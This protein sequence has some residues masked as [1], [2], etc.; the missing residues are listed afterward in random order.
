MRLNAPQFAACDVVL[1]SDDP[2]SAK[3][4]RVVSIFCAHDTADPRLLGLMQGFSWT[5]PAEIER[6][7]AQERARIRPG[8]ARLLEEGMERGEF[9]RLSVP[10]LMNSIW[11][12]YT[13]GVRAAVFEGADAQ[14]C[15]RRIMAELNNLLRPDGCGAR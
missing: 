8:L 15:T 2:P 7:N 3:L 11:A 10:E 14:E 12:I 6:L 13:W 1:A 9:R 4:E 5:W